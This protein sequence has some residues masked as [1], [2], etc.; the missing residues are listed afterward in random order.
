M[1]LFVLTKRSG[2]HESTNLGSFLL[3]FDS[4]LGI[5]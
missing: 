3:F 2:V 5:Q 4:T 1:T